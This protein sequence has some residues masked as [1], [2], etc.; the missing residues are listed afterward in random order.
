MFTPSHSDY[1]RFNESAMK[2][3]TLTCL[4]IYIFCVIACGTSDGQGLKSI[5]NKGKL[6]KGAKGLAGMKD[7]AG[8]P[9]QYI[10]YGNYKVFTSEPIWLLHKNSHEKFYYNLITNSIIGTYDVNLQSGFARNKEELDWIKNMHVSLE[11]G[12]SVNIFDYTVHRNPD[13]DMFLQVASYGD[14]GG[15]WLPAAAFYNFISNVNSVQDT[16][17]ESIFTIKRDLINKYKLN[18]SQVGIIL[19]IQNIPS[20]LNDEHFAEQF[21]DFVV[22]LKRRIVPRGEGAKFGIKL[23]IIHDENNFYYQNGAMFRK[24]ISY[25]DFLI[26]KNYVLDFDELNAETYQWFIRENYKLLNSDIDSLNKMGVPSEKLIVEFAYVGLHAKKDAMTGK[27]IPQPDKPLIAYDQ[28]ARLAGK[29]FVRQA[30]DM[31][32]S[33]MTVYEM[34]NSEQF[35]FNSEHILFQKYNLLKSKKIRGISIYGIGYNN[36]ETRQQYW[37]SIADAFGR[38]PDKLIWYFFGTFF[39]FLSFGFPYSVVRHWQVRNVLAR[40][41]KHLLPALG[42]WFIVV[43]ASLLCFNIIPRTSTG[44]FIG[45]GIL[46]FFVLVIILRKYLSKLFS[47]FKK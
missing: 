17:F 21:V 2:Q 5:F 29:N 42:G 20:N 43:F 41:K 35:Q 36:L 33:S 25:A 22:E 24:L 16:L 47:L 46:A 38:I 4:L 9:G 3:R 27:L 13:I 7:E 34:K 15:G 32:D 45:V 44:V 26:Y 31:S 30:A 19:D 40:F 11:T 18:A 23:P 39:G 6:K 14:T 12:D 37:K 1:L 28:M 8:D 10:L